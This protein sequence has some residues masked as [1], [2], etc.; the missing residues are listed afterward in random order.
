VGRFL[1]RIVKGR[2]S[3]GLAGY[4]AA[5]LLVTLLLYPPAIGKAWETTYLRP[6]VARLS[7]HS[8]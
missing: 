6:L 5:V 3:P 2:L 8:P 4:L 1:S 7:P